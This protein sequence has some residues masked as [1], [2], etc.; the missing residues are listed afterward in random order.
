MAVLQEAY[1]QRMGM[2]HD[3]IQPTVQC[4]RGRKPKKKSCVNKQ[5]EKAVSKTTEEIQDN[6]MKK[7]IRVRSRSWEV[8]S[9]SCQ[10]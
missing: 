6:L 1:E 7:P 10:R 8:S 3:Y 5:E 2:L 4:S 9:I